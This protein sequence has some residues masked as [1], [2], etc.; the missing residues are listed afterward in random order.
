V[1]LS[2][3]IGGFIKIFGEISKGRIALVRLILLK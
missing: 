1:A 2:G 3:D